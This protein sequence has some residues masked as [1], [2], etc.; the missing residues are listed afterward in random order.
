MMK[1]SQNPGQHQ[2]AFW[3]VIRCL[4]SVVYLHQWSIWGVWCAI[5]K[6]G[7]RGVPSPA[8]D[9]KEPLLDNGG[10]A[11][12]T[13]FG[14]QVNIGRWFCIFVAIWRNLNQKMENMFVWHLGAGRGIEGICQNSSVS[15]PPLKR[16]L[17][18]DQAMELQIE[19]HILLSSATGIISRQGPPSKASPWGPC[20]LEQLSLRSA[21]DW[22]THSKDRIVIK[23][24]SWGGRWADWKQ[25]YRSTSFT[26]LTRPTG[27][28]ST[29]RKF[30]DQQTIFRPTENFVL[31]NCG[32][33]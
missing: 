17:L 5:G 13:N 30:L 23:S 14:H 10:W 28:F 2:A 24:S 26:R 25:H 7:K 29:K 19:K 32:M 18:L 9:H 16:P 21:S 22:I 33:H 6:G 11:V 20:P 12:S 27:N 8:Q 3:R 15:P 4:A 31:I 1:Y